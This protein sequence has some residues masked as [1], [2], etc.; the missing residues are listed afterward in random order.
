[1]TKLH[2]TLFHVALY[3]S[4]VLYFIAYAG[5]MHYDPA[6]L[7]VLHDVIKYFVV[8][9]LMIRFNPFS[10]SKTFTSFDR[11][12][13]FDSAIFL[14]TSSTLHSATSGMLGHFLNTILESA[15]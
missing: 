4:Y 7:G 2:E 15:M 12:I 8:F 9:F 10:K 3:A 14:F 13:V 1:M 5:I 11:E 6:Y